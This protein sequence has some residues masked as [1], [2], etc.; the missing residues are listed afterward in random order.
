MKS[1]GKSLTVAYVS[2]EK[3]Q[4]L[5]LKQL[6]RVI[7]EKFPRIFLKFSFSSCIDVF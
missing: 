4:K 6:A 1:S 2:F 5:Y 7:L 3:I